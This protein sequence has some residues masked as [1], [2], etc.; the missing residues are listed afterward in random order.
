MS[1]LTVKKENNRFYLQSGDHWTP[2][3]ESLKNLADVKKSFNCDDIELITSAGLPYRTIEV[4][5]YD[6]LNLTIKDESGESRIY[7][8]EASEKQI[9]DYLMNQGK[10]LGFNQTVIK[11]SKPIKEPVNESKP[12]D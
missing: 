6:N 7:Y 10:D 8:P 11:F 3:S 5:N 9:C 1:K 4:V 2:L 12:E